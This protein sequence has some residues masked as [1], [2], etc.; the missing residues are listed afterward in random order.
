MQDLSTLKNRKTLL[1]NIPH[2]NIKELQLWDLVH[3]NLIGPYINSSRQHNPGGAIMQKD[4][5]LTCMTM[6]DPATGW[7]DIVEIPSFD[8]DEVTAGNDECIN[9]S[10]VRVSQ[11]FNNTWLCR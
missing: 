11:L 2:N 9:K 8:L 7:F 1:G 3:V 4:Y 5:S 10:S 6:I